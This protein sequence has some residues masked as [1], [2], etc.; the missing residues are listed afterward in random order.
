VIG[1]TQAEL[2]SPIGINGLAAGLRRAKECSMRA[3]LPGLLLGAAATLFGGQSFMQAVT[4]TNVNSQYVIESVSVAGVLVDDVDAAASAKLP[5]PLGERLVALIGE[6][7]DVAALENL[8]AEIRRELH[9]GAVTEHL[10]KGSAPDR[11]KV[12]FEVVQKDLSFDV[13]LPKFFYHSEQNLTGELDASAQVKQNKFAFGLVSNGDDLTERYSGLT[14]RFDS[15][16]LFP[17]RRVRFAVVFEDYHEKWNPMTRDAAGESGLDLYHSRWN[18][19]PQVVFTVARPLEV[20]LGTSFE[21][22]QS[23]SPVV[24]DRAA[25]AATADVHYGHKIEGRRVQQQIDARY[26]LRVATR[27]LASTYAYARH[28][29]SVKYEAKSGRHTAS[30]EFIAGAI[31]GQAPMFDRFALGNSSTLRGWDR[32]TLDPLGGSRVTHNE[33]TYGY[34]TSQGTVETFYDAGSVWDAG[35]TVKLRQSVGTGFRKGIFLLAMAFPLHG[36][37]VEPVFMA[38]MNY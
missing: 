3:S 27:A 24:G 5:R 10:S 12:N 31:D 19:A 25:N 1:A 6:R 29:I 20:S 13:S 35:Q 23:E 8:A 21:K 15:A 28:M 11:I 17:T 37:H 33:I 26:N 14:A 2:N 7:C 32:Y 22:T 36:G 9:L 30:D 38:G 34:R 4:E 18:V 16:P